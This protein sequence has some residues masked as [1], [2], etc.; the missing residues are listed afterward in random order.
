MDRRSDP[1]LPVTRPRGRAAFGLP[2]AADARLQLLDRFHFEW[3]DHAEVLPYGSQRLLALLALVPDGMR[4]RQVAAVLWPDLPKDRSPGSLRTL[5]WRVRQQCPGLLVSEGGVVRFR[6]GV[7]VDVRH[8]Q[9]M[10]ARWRAWRLD[11]GSGGQQFCRS[12]LDDL[13]APSTLLP[14]WYDDWVLFHRE[15]LS[16]MRLELLTHAAGALLEAGRHVQALDLALAAVASEPL[17]EELHKLVARI[18]LAQGNG[19]EALRQYELCAALFR[20]DLGVEPTTGFAAL[21]S[22]SP[23]PPQPGRASAMAPPA[24]TFSTRRARQ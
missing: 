23:G 2:T 5:M 8:L 13:V 11:N 12:E 1:R 3:H 6:D 22:V 21:L 19:S 9:E 14:G 15:R 4:R 17:D 16:A 24:R 7:D 10:A 18:H 20:R